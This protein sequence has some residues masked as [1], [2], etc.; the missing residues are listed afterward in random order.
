MK[1]QL[2]IFDV[3]SVLINSDPNP[4]LL[5]EGIV[6][7]SK[8]LGARFIPGESSEESTSRLLFEQYLK[9]GMQLFGWVPE[10]LSELHHKT[11][12][13]GISA[14][15]RS[16]LQRPIRGLS[17]GK[18]LRDLFDV[19]VSDYTFDRVDRDSEGLKIVLEQYPDISKERII[20]ISANVC[21]I[22][23]AQEYGMAIAIVNGQSV[24]N[25]EIIKI[26]N[27]SRENGK[28]NV[29]LI[30][31]HAYLLPLVE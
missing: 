26:H 19:F 16:E 17:R 27:K 18:Y 30:T 24:G 13:A 10:L 25:S 20:F 14:L 8:M 23:A 2:L 11:S 7:V 1:Y 31:D 9:G 29:F 28:E 22:K 5:V 15:S 21:A 12:I 3:D 4:S 6:T